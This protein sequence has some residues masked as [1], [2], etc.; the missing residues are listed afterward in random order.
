[1]EILPARKQ[2]AMI[3]KRE[4]CREERLYLTRPDLRLVDPGTH[5]RINVY[6]GQ[7]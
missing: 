2:A 1:M 3:R 7:T 6:S 5:A 4:Y